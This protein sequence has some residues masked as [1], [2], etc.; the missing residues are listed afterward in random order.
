MIKV[1]FKL[2]RNKNVEPGKKEAHV[3]LQNPKG[4][5]ANA[6]GVFTSKTTN[7]MK[8]YTDFTVI[9][10]SFNDVDIVMY[11]DRNGYMYEKGT[12]PVKLFLEGELVAES[13]LDLASNF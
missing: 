6:K 9:D 13:N 7:E 3:V 8:K 12:Y 11:I 5:V 10:Y 1:S 4:K 2:L